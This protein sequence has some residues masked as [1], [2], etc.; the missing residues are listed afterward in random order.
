MAIKL[1]LEEDV[2]TL[3]RSGDIVNVKPGYARNYLIPKGLA[4]MADK[5]ALRRQEKLVAERLKRAAE[6]KKEAEAIATRLE[7]ISLTTVVKVDQE[8]HMYGSVSTQDLLHLVKEQQNIELEK[9]SIHLKHPIK[10]IGVHDIVLKLKEGV[11]ATFHLKVMSEE[12]FQATQEE[13]PANP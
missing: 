7:G 4:V 13:Q 2:D 8:G 12:G 1:L 6:D 3:G 5:R 11:T 9:K 10:A